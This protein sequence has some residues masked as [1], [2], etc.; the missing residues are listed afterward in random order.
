MLENDVVRTAIHERCVRTNKPLPKGGKKD[1]KDKEKKK[2]EDVRS[3]V[4]V[5]S[6]AL[7]ALMMVLLVEFKMQALEAL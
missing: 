6:T 7:L 5:L 4:A 1:G 2:A 3:V